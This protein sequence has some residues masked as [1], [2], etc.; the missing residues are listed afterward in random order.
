[1]MGFCICVTELFQLFCR[2]VQ[3]SEVLVVIGLGK[4]KQLRYWEDENAD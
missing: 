4:R 2:Q 1:M 3:L